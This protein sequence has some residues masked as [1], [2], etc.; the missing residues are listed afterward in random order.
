MLFI[1]VFRLVGCDCRANANTFNC[2]CCFL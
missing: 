1:L 2:S